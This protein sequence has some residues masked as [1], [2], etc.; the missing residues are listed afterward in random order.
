MV[1]FSTLTETSPISRWA[2][3]GATTRQREKISWKSFCIVGRSAQSRWAEDISICA[4]FPHNNSYF[5]TIATFLPSRDVRR[6]QRPPQASQ[7]SWLQPRHRVLRAG[8]LGGVGRRHG[9]GRARTDD[10]RSQN[11]SLSEERGGQMPARAARREGD[12]HRHRSVRR[13]NPGRRV[14]SRGWQFG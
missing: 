12:H 9:E 5:R 7:V 4:P 10:Q 1:F 3:A 2:K 8:A 11:S 6:N 13:E 14:G